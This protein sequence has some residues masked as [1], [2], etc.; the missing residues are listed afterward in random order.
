M[1]YSEYFTEIFIFNYIGITLRKFYLTFIILLP[2]NYNSFIAIPINVKLNIK[3]SV[4][5]RI[6]EM[7]YVS[8]ISTLLP[9][10]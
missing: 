9:I 5:T 2:I 6:N 4:L 3:K 10:L 8:S 1:I 7:L